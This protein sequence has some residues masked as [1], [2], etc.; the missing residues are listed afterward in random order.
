MT[1]F[2][3][4]DTTVVF[5]MFPGCNFIKKTLVDWLTKV[6]LQCLD[7]LEEYWLP[8]LI[9]SLAIGMSLI[10]FVELAVHTNSYITIIFLG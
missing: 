2:F 3:F 1:D 5:S 4:F 6:E 10:V 7:G 8:I 9:Y